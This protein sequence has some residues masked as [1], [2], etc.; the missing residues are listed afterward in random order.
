VQLYQE[1]F[2]SRPSRPGFQKLGILKWII[3]AYLAK[4]LHGLGDGTII[5]KLDY[6]S[7]SVIIECENF[8][9]GVFNSTK[10]TYSFQIIKDIKYAMLNFDSSKVHGTMKMTSIPPPHFSDG[11]VLGVNEPNPESI[12]L[13]PGLYYNQPMAGATVEIDATLASGKRV[14][15]HGSGGHGRLWAVDSWFVYLFLL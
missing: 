6:V 12:N 3:H 10:K 9:K 2:C 13:A 7:E 14:A 4:V 11:T 15:F 5:Q 1:M 8:V